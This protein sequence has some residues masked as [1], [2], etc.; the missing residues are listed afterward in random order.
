MTLRLP[1]S[2]L[3]MALAAPVLVGCS[4]DD[5]GKPNAQAAPAASYVAV[6][7]GRI[8]I[9]GGLLKLSMPRDGVVADIKVREG[10]HVRKGQ[11]LAVLD[12]K[13]AQLAVSAAEAE[14]KQSKAQGNLLEAR[15]KA[16]QQRATRLQAAATAGA[17]DGQS[18]DDARDAATQLQG[19]LDN[20]RAAEAMGEQK[21]EAARYELAQRSLVAPVDAQIVERNIQPGAAV[22]PQGGAA[23][24]LLPE[25]A[26]LVR[27]ELN[28][29]FVSAVHDGMQAQVIDD[30]GSGV[31]P[32]RAHVQRI[33]A[34]FGPSALEEDPLIRAN[35]RTV[36]CVLAFDEPPPPSLRI[37]QRVIVQFGDKA[38][39][40]PA[41][42]G[43]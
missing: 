21:L 10:D 1:L 8:D 34:V 2:F 15:L 36:E 20:A 41:K 6:A 28:E 12:T 7:R 19:E 32:L 26:R 35:T 23:F 9:E 33:G 27:A 13:P 16:A 17:G 18:A 43:A 29:S 38:A 22:S 4:H 14:L 39:A 3:V 30:S 37:G 11:V 31:P 25:G 40:A 42:P 24:V 5:S